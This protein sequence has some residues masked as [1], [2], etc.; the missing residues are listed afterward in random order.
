MTEYPDTELSLRLR[1][2]WGR[3][4]RPEFVAR[5]EETLGYRPS[6][7][8]FLDIERTDDLRAKLRTRSTETATRT[9][10]ESEWSSL[11]ARF[12]DFA[13]S[14]GSEHF[15][16][17]AFFNEWDRI[18]ALRVRSAVLLASAES[19]WRLTSDSVGLV[20]EDASDGFWLDYTHQK[21]MRGDDE[22][23][24]RCWGEFRSLAD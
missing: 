23:E 14:I 1:A 24:L 4:L 16:Y 22:Y 10:P 12:L 21:Q 19:F 20:T 2:N 6:N 5:I 9:W 7:E 18:G 13:A 8:D 3:R 15:S 17:L 11:R